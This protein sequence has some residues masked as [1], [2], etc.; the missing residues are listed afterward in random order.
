MGR[1]EHIACGY[2]EYAPG[3]DDWGCLVHRIDFA[4][5]KGWTPGTLQSRLDASVSIA[6]DD[7]L[8][9]GTTPSMPVGVERRNA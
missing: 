4:V 6:L 2:S 9:S 7:A 5:R 1:L 8:H 3:C